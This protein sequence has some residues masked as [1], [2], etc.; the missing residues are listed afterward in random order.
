MT[1]DSQTGIEYSAELEQRIVDLESEAQNLRNMIERIGREK[2]TCIAD[3]TSFPVIN[4]IVLLGIFV[5]I[6]LRIVLMR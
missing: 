6:I 2:R 3:R 5:L 1:A 4:V